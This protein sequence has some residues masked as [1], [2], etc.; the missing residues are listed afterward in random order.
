[1]SSVPLISLYHKQIAV[2][3]K[4]LSDKVNYFLSVLLPYVFIVIMTICK[5]E[6]ALD[7]AILPAEVEK[8]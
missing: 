3:L 8:V 2:K 1:M 7:L 4:K 6:N 5:I